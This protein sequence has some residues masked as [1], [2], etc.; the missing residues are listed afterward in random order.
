[1]LNLPNQL[2]DRF[3][4]TRVALFVGA[5]CSRSAGLPG[6]EELLRGLEASEGLLNREDKSCLKS[7]FRNTDTY[8]NVAEFFKRQFTSHYREYIQ[9]VFDPPPS[10]K[11]LRPPKYLRTLRHFP[12]RRVITTN[13]D[14][15]LE[16]ALG[17]RWNSIT[18]QDK[19]EL[20]RFL[21]EE[22]P[23]IFHVHGRADRFGTLVHARSEYEVLNGPEGRQA[24]DFLQRL[25]E[26]YTILLIGYRLG[27]PVIRW[28]FDHLRS[29]WNQTPDWYTLVPQATEDERRQ[30]LQER[31]LRL[32]SYMEDP[33]KCMEDYE[34]GLNKWF[35][36]R[37]WSFCFT[38]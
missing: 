18:W 24:R 19:E 1:M 34:E 31:N 6:W 13:F 11:S 28:V 27:D 17:T 29:D 20:P 21:R 36:E 26:N 14:K 32:L 35:E 22:R 7:W 10:A 30:E 2:L 9:N 37:D 38:H 33:P 8:P 15:L 12:I 16:E 25:F 3:R 4:Q 5:G 23:V